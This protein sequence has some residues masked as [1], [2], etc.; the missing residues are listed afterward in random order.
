MA[1]PICGIHVEE[2]FNPITEEEGEDE[3]PVVVFFPNH[4]EITRRQRLYL[5]IRLHCFYLFDISF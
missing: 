4:A 2:D 5:L 1:K 3:D